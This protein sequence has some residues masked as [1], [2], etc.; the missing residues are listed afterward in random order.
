WPDLYD[1]FGAWVRQIWRTGATDL[2]HLDCH[3]TSTIGRTIAASRP[4][5]LT[6]IQPARSHASR[7]LIFVRADTPNCAAIALVTFTSTCPK[8]DLYSTYRYSRVFGSIGQPARG[9]RSQ[10]IGTRAK[11]DGKRFSGSGRVLW[12]SKACSGTSNSVARSKSGDI[13]N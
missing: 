1:R 3:P 2:A 11:W 12:A 7:P 13:T 9:L 5:R 10:L 4:V 8:C 6:L